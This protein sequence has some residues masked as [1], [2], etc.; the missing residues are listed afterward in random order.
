MSLGICGATVSLVN[1]AVPV[2]VCQVVGQGVRGLSLGLGEVP[3]QAVICRSRA[4]LGPAP[5]KGQ[6]LI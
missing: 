2:H 4:L 1:E 3:E 5:E 6:L